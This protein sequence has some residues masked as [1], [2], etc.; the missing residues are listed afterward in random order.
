MGDFTRVDAVVDHVGRIVLNQ[1]PNNF[2]SVGMIG[3][4]A[5]ALESFD[6]DDD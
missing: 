3:E 6:A 1:P 2:F 5:D 4:I